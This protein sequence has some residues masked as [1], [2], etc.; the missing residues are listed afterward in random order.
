M[1]SSPSFS[2]PPPPQLLP[3]LLFK[4]SSSSCAQIKWQRE[5]VKKLRNCLEAATPG[6]AESAKGNR[7]VEFRELKSLRPDPHADL[8]RRHQTFT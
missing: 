2:P 7:R 3:L 8:I 4:S 1:S 6:V 5:E